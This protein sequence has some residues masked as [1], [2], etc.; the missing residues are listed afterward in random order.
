[1]SDLRVAIDGRLWGQ[2]GIGRYI[3]ELCHA[4]LQADEGIQILVFGSAHVHQR[5][6]E[7]RTFQAP[8]Y[9][10]SEQVLGGLALRRAASQVSLFHAPHYNVPLLMPRPYVLTVHDLIPF[11]FREQFGRVHTELG[12]R[13]LRRATRGAAQIIVNSHCTERDLVAAI[14]QCRGKVR[15]IHLGVSEFFSPGIK[16]ADRDVL[17][18]QGVTRYI[19]TLSSR[20]PYKNLSTAI[21]AFRLVQRA[22]P[23]ISLVS[24]GPGGVGVENGVIHLGYVD[25]ERL[26]SLYRSAECLVFPSLYE[27]F[28]LPVLEAMACGCPVVCSTGSGLDEVCGNAAVQR[29]PHD[30]DAFAEDILKILQ[31]IDFRASLVQEGMLQ[32]KQFSWRQAALKTLDVYRS[33]SMLQ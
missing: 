22:Y 17:N 5:R 9:S 3:S 24:V 26:R 29:D 6:L 33:V 11:R 19:L 25:D 7:W 20:K 14:P 4:L 16:G 30:V 23:D 21:A 18:S 32:A 8:I 27:G 12:F 2:T 31:N 28:G 15:V 13:V 1:M 10:L